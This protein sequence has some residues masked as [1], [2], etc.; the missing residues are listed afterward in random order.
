MADFDLLKVKL[1][2]GFFFLSQKKHLLSPYGV[3]WDI[4]H[5][6]RFSRLGCTRAQERRKLKKEKKKKKHKPLY[7][8]HMYIMPNI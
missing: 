6:N 1:K 7:V 3:V 2:N 5:E 8:G 4:A